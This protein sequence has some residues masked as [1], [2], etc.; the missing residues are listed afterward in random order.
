MRK[1]ILTLLSNE[2]IQGG[3]FLTASSFLINLLNYFFYFFAARILGPTGY[4]E[5]VAFFSYI[6][7]I[8]VPMTV[9][10]MI[11]IQKVGEKNRH[12]VEYARALENHFWQKVKKWWFLFIPF[13]IFI[14][15]TPQ[16]TNLPPVIAYFIIPFMI[17]SF[18]SVIYSSVLQGLKLFLIFSI[19]NLV[20][21]VLKF[22]GIGLPL[23]RLGDASAVIAFYFFSG[24]ITLIIFILIIKRQVFRKQRTEATKIVL[25][26]TIF[27][28]I[29]DPQFALTLLSILAITAFSNIDIIFV[30]K[31]YSS[32]DAGI[33]SSWSMLAKVILYATGPMI[34]VGYVF[35]SGKRHHYVHERIL[36]FSVGILFLITLIGFVGY[37][38]VGALLVNML[39]G[40]RFNAVLPYLGK[41]SLFGGLYTL[42]TLFNHYYLAKKDKYALLLF[43]VIPIYISFLFFIPKN[44]SAIVNLN[45]LFSLATLVLYLIAFFSPKLTGNKPLSD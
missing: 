7:L 41:A 31:Y 39:F 19:F 20:S 17:S 36:L 9:F 26:R 10:S 11:V 12:Q 16:L 15:F 37:Q 32:I 33:Y 2:F 21:T 25:Q 34:Q 35:F 22:V 43:S 27:R 44:I 30:K 28:F 45:I 14:P 38:T 18:I 29:F 13:I 5:I 42:L 6:V 40:E 1:K 24:L 3:F 8:S 23:F 4:G